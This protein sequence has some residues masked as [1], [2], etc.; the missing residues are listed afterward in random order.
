[1]LSYVSCHGDLTWENVNHHHRTDR[2]NPSL[3]KL[4]SCFIVQAAVLI[5]QQESKLLL[6]IDAVLQN[7]I[8]WYCSVS[9]FSYTTFDTFFTI[10]IECV[11]C[12][13]LLICV[14]HKVHMMM[15]RM[16]MSLLL[17]VESI[18]SGQNKC[19]GSVKSLSI[20]QSSKQPQ[21][22]VQ[23]ISTLHEL[24]IILF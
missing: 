2:A 8:L 15:M 10:I 24:H 12:Q 22:Y 11:G 5:I 23:C 16:W 21:K 3:I 6:N 19:L 14:E 9:I 17:Q 1:M 4:K 13:H 20:L 7:E 18:R